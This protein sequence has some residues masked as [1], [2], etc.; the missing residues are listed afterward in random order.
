MSGSNIPRLYA[1]FKISLN[2]VPPYISA[3]RSP[4]YRQFTSLWTRNKTLFTLF[5][6][7]GLQTTTLPVVDLRAYALKN[8]RGD[9]LKKNY[10]FTRVSACKDCTASCSSWVFRRCLFC[11]L[12]ATGLRIRAKILVFSDRDQKFLGSPTE[13]R[14]D[15]KL[16]ENP[17]RVRVIS[18][19]RKSELFER[20]RIIFNEFIM[21]IF[22]FSLTSLV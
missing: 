17:N 13:F 3:R 19:V 21:Q 10:I 18:R 9:R 8:A 2:L 11:T 12:H 5:S 4:L 1:D 6:F 22:S 20:F 7:F 15:P 16:P 14:P